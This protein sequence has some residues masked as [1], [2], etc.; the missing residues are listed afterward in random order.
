M[1]G[2]AAHI[3]LYWLEEKKRWQWIVSFNSSVGNTGFARSEKA[4]LRRAKNF[5]LNT[6]ARQGAGDG[7]FRLTVT[8][9][10]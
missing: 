2:E 8:G 9:K 10:V 4:A 6:W 3:S 5:M 7:V 1:S